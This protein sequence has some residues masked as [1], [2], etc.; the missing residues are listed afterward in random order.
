[1]S[2]TGGCVGNW[3]QENTDSNDLYFTQG[4]S[5]AGNSKRQDSRSEGQERKKMRKHHKELRGNSQQEDDGSAGKE[6]KAGQ[7]MKD[8]MRQSAKTT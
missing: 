7:Y 6:R 1:M 5:K 3:K 2:D 4:V 8:N